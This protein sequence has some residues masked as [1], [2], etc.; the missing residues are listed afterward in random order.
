MFTLHSIPFGMGAKT[1]KGSTSLT[2]LQ[3]P[4]EAAMKILYYFML[5]FFQFKR[6]LQL[7]RGRVNY[8][9]PLELENRFKRKYSDRKDLYHELEKF[10]EAGSATGDFA[11]DIM[12]KFDEIDADLREMSQIFK[13]KYFQCGGMDVEAEVLFAILSAKK[14]SK[15]LEI[16]V[17]NGYSSRYMYEAACQNNSTVVSIDWPRMSEKKL[18]F[19]QRVISFG[20]SLGW[21]LDTGTIVDLREGGVVPHELHAGWMVPPM[22]RLEVK[23]TNYFGDVFAILPMIEQKFDVIVIDAMKDYSSRINL[24]ELAYN[25]LDKGGV[26]IFDGYWINAAFS[27]FCAKHACAEYQFGKVGCLCK[28]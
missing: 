15:F 14:N 5:K 16:G 28:L 6:R 27:D 21:L 11:I 1:C 10:S 12:R 7:I 9:Y 18:N 20:N 22:L 4:S 2:V 3:K 24:L 13:G 23:A 8:Q 19:K 25:K 17:A 26:I